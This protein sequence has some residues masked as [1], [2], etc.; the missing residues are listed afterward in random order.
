MKIKN[1]FIM[2]LKSFL[3]RVMYHLSPL[4]SD[5]FYIKKQFKYL[6][7]YDVNLEN[8]KTFQEK[9]QWLKL[10]DRKPIYTKMV[11]KYDA[12]EF[13]AEKV[14]KEFV[15]PTIGVYNSFDEIDF[16]TLPDSFVMK[17]THDSGT[18]IVCHDKNALNKKEVQKFLSKRQHRNYYFTERE[19]PYKDV[20]PRIIIEKNININGEDLSDYKFYCFNGEPK[21]LYITT[22]R[23]KI[24][25]LK[26]D[27]YLIDGTHIDCTQ[28][29][30]PNNEIQPKLPINFDRM[31]KLATDL[32]KG[33][34]HLRVD[35]YEIDGQIFVG[36][37]TFSDGGGYALFTPEKYNRIFGEWIKLPDIK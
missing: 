25:G 30:Y 2:T 26:E 5:E 4:F 22:N 19:W 13:I 1:L 29:G 7:G 3:Y 9:L 33:I 10:H 12:K 35:F 18:V 21:A 20:K 31:K 11:D 32:S 37:L 14:G 24:G 17:T 27:Y 8:P 6:L 36:E 28:I 16:T 34:P 23:G 15:I